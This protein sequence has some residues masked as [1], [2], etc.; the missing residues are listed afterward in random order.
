[1]LEKIADFYE[2]DV[3]ALVGGLSKL[4]EPIILVF[5]GTTVGG[6]MIAMYLPI[7]KLAGGAGE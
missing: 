5:L 4:I 6:L 1:M 7:F 3:E 2:A